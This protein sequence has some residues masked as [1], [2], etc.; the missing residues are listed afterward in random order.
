[1]EAKGGNRF[2]KGG[3]VNNVTENHADRERSFLRDQVSKRG[4]DESRI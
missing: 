1:M 2:R 3:V 4:E